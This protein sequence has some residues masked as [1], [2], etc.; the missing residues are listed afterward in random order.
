M[1]RFLTLILS[2]VM[3]LALF[4]S[5]D[6]GDNSGNNESSNGQDSSQVTAYA[7]ENE[8]YLMG[9]CEAVSDINKEVESTLTMDYV[10]DVCGT[11]EVKSYRL[12]M[13]F[14]RV[15]MRDP[16]SNT[17]YVNQENAQKFHDFIA[18]LKAQG[19]ERFICMTSNYLH[20]YG[21]DPTTYNVI[22]DP[23]T[24]QAE[25][26]EFL[27]LLGESFRVLA[28][29][30]PEIDY[31]EPTNEPDLINGQN[32]CRNGYE[33]G[34]N[35]NGDYLY[36]DYDGAH[37]VADMCWYVTKAVKSVDEKNTVLLPALCGYSSTEYYLDE[38]YNAIESKTLPTGEEKADIKADNYF[39]ILNWH[40]YLLAEGEPEMNE[41]WV[42]LQKRIFAVAVNH[43]DGDSPVWFTEMGFTDL[44]N[45]DYKEEMAENVVKL[46]DYVRSELTFVET[47]FMF[48]VSNLTGHAVMNEYENNFG[49]FYSL[50]DPDWGIAGSPKPIVIALYKWFK[51]ENADLTPLYKWA[52]NEDN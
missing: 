22:P 52:V 27:K 17:V 26:V 30:F 42:D 21:Y 49:L 24:E 23:L 25:Y 5:C 15:L 50:Q 19:V 32:L 46:M 12:W 33:W 28:E 29:E 31:F 7:R 1:K 41:Y 11:L 48:R 6:G 14:S 38:I 8:D 51:G 3:S 18:K 2:A 4:A 35:D 13:H 45:D 20:P 37:I 43:G 39:E 16:K 44:G 40:P 36:S 34:G 9:L 47:V 10:A